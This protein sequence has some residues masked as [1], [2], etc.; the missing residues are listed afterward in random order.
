VKPFVIHA[1]AEAEFREAMERYEQ[2]RAGL[3]GK[4]RAEF[5]VTL[6]RVRDNPLLYA[7]DD[8]SAVRHCPLRRFPYTLVYLDLEDRIWIAAVAHQ[9]RRP[10]YWARRR[11][12]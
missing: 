4:F 6:Q 9:R 8:D 12:N 3:G 5:E 1:A 7:A 11:P 10:G 2:Q